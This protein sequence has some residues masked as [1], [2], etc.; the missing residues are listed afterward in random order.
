MKESG[1]ARAE[2]ESISK[3]MSTA[4]SIGRLAVHFKGNF[5][6]RPCG[7]HKSQT[8]ASRDG[9][10]RWNDGPPTPGT[11]VLKFCQSGG[12]A[13]HCPRHT[14]LHHHSPF[15]I[16]THPHVVPHL[17]TV[18]LR[19]G[20]SSKIGSVHR[21]SDFSHLSCPWLPVIVAIHGQVCVA[22]TILTRGAGRCRQKPIC[23]PSLRCAGPSHRMRCS[24]ITTPC[25]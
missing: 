6:R 17:S 19:P 2:R 5:Q 15:N 11:S 8:R 22:C 1:G 7:L 23:T 16:G 13:A 21:P 12:D 20:F 25:P 24:A 14:S 9:G 10:V 3:S 4:Q 18:V